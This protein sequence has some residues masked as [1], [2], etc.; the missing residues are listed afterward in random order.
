MDHAED[1]DLDETEESGIT[2][3]NE[4]IG[5]SQS[6]VSMQSLIDRSVSAVGQYRYIISITYVM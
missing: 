4:F 2:K 6:T 1:E 5:W 3:D